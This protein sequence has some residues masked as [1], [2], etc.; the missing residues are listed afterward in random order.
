MPD[1][2]DTRFVT[3]I[4]NVTGAKTRI[5]SIQP[6]NC[7]YNFGG[8]FFRTLI[9]QDFYNTYPEYVNAPD[10]GVTVPI[11]G[12]P[13]EVNYDRMIIDVI[14]AWKELDADV[15]TV[16]STATS[17]ATAASAAQST[18]DSA[19][20]AANAAVIQTAGNGTFGDLTW[21]GTPPSGTIT[22]PFQWYKH[23]SVVQL[24]GYVKATSPGL[25]VSTLS[26][27]LPS[28]CPTPADLPDQAN[29]SWVS[30]GSGG[31]ASGINVALSGN[32][33]GLYKNS[34]GDYEIRLNAT[35]VIAVSYA[36][37]Q[38]TYMAA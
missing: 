12:L 35:A 37:I 31:L 36:S 9:A 18:A 4:S 5:R 2:S 19:L 25:L 10:D 13:W 21:D 32:S 8:G 6:V 17:A 23:G 11:P 16:E 20:T 27:D 3:D 14:A 30:F 26:M 7:R 33:C 34:S 29:D 22:K 24:F 38:L 1:Y 15:T 28:S